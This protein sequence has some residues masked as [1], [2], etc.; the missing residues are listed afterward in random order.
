MGIRGRVK[1][2]GNW[3]GVE[4]DQLEVL[5]QGDIFQTLILRR[6]EATS[7]ISSTVL[8]SQLLIQHGAC[9]SLICIRSL[10]VS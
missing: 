5:A 1:R 7:V 10:V 8:F 6:Y 3:C 2:Q 4:R 9:V